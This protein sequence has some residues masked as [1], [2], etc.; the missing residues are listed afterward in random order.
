MAWMRLRA[1]GKPGHGS[2]LHDD[3]AVTQASPR[4]SPG[5]ATT[6]SRWSL[7]DTVRAFLD[8]HDAS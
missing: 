3:N 2:F 5:W 1:R 8:Q 4:R 7:T 6:R